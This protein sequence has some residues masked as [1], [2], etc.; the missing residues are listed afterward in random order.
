[1][2][3]DII[4]LST[5][6]EKRAADERSSTLLNEESYAAVF[7]EMIAHLCNAGQDERCRPVA[8]QASAGLAQ[9]SLSIANA[10]QAG[11][12]SAL[13]LIA[14]EVRSEY[15]KLIEEVGQ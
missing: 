11:D 10:I 8:L 3:A 9:V 15:D 5:V 1:M 7:L 13:Q 4:N 12:H 6:R 2:T 14:N